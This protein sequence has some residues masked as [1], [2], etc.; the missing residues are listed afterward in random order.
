[1]EGVFFVNRIIKLRERIATRP[2]KLIKENRI[3]FILF[4]NQDSSMEN[5][6]IILPTN[7]FGDDP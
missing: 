1:L 4:G 3:A 6:F 2:G 5:L 7:S